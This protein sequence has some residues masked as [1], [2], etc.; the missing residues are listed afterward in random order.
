MN[1]IGIDIGMLKCAACVMDES[2]NILYEAGFDNSIKY[3]KEF[4]DYVKQKYGSCTAVC[5]ST[6]NMWIRVFATLEENDISVVLANPYRVKLIANS[7]IKT[8]KIDARALAALLRMR[9]VP[10]CYV[11]DR[12]SRDEI[13]LL[14]HRIASAGQDPN[15][16]P[17]AQSALQV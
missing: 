4:A 2:G 5:E 17:S 7:S 15:S 14:R 3:T 1:Y 16:K 13:A 12:K 9:P 10:K 11:Q 8:D 6:G